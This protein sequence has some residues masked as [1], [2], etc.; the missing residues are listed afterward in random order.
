MKGI[1]H[2]LDLLELD[3]HEIALQGLYAGADDLPL[4]RPAQ[5]Q[6]RVRV[7]CAVAGNLQKR[8]D[9]ER[10]YKLVLGG[11]YLRQAN[12][13]A[14]HLRIVVALDQGY[15]LVPDAVAGVGGIL[16][17]FVNSEWQGIFS[18]V[19]FDFGT[20]RVD[21]RADDIFRAPV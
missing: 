12:K 16:V 2:A 8:R 11:G 13:G 15:Q 19:S 17:A 6:E 5:A 9:R 4:Q 7:D 18:D 20:E 10:F 14:L 3:V 1:D 21:Q